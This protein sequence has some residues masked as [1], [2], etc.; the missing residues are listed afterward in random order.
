MNTK[1]KDLKEKRVLLKSFST[2]NQ[3][4]KTIKHICRLDNDGIQISVLG[5]LEDVNLD[6]NFSNYWSELKTYCANDLKLTS[7]FGMVSN[8][9]IGTFFIA[10]FLAPMFLQKINGKTI[11][12]MSTGLYGI[13]RGI[14]ASE[15]QATAYL[16]LLNSG[17]YVLIL[18][19]IEA[20][21]EIYKRILEK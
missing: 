6:S 8:P 9:E 1:V 7:S 16:R 17:S 4:E 15:T 3:I 18:R 12:S 5:K 19:G 14:G 20:K 13:L 2:I 11:G 21:L 10:G